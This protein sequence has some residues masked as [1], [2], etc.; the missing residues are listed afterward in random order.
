MKIKQ[1]S[2]IVEREFE[3]GMITNPTVRYFQQKDGILDDV[4]K[5][6]L[7]NYTPCDT[8]EVCL[9]RVAND[10]YFVFWFNFKK[11]SKLLRFCLFFYF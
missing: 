9:K 11:C 1:F 2:D 4:S 5:F 3:I 10:K 7:A 6:V 8:A